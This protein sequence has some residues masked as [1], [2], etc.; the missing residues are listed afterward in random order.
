MLSYTCTYEHMRLYQDIFTILLNVMVCLI[1]LMTNSA[2]LFCNLWKFWIIERVTSLLATLSVLGRS[3][4]NSQKG[5]KLHFHVPIR[6]LD[7]LYVSVVEVLEVVASDGMVACV[8]NGLNMILKLFDATYN[9]CNLNLSGV[10]LKWQYVCLV[11]NLK[12]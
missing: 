7:L 5:W 12:S 10:T 8:D 2:M 1:F 4:I 3:D 9:I 11:A 6:A